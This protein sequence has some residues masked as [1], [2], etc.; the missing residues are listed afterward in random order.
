MALTRSPPSTNSIAAPLAPLGPDRRV[1]RALLS[2]RRKS[3]SDP[4]TRKRK[5]RDAFSRRSPRFLLLLDQAGLSILLLIGIP[6]RSSEA[7]NYE[8]TQ[9]AVIG[10]HSF[11]GREIGGASPARL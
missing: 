9:L 2:W 1:I 11:S 3:S 4:H 5:R 7:R 10:C 6:C 8:Q